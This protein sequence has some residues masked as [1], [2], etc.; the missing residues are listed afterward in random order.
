MSIDTSD[1]KQTFAAAVLALVIL[2]GA[3]SRILGRIL[4]WNGRAEVDPGVWCPMRGMLIVEEVDSLDRF[5]FSVATRVVSGNRTA[6]FIQCLLTL[7]S[8]VGGQELV[9]WHRRGIWGKDCKSSCSL[10]LQD[11]VQQLRE[12]SRKRCH[13]PAEARSLRDF[14]FPRALPVHNRASEPRHNKKCTRYSH[15]PTKT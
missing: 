2:A 15:N 14:S 1:V 11:H 6:V 13:W 12:L 7:L 8:N 10:S 5:S 4:S 9:P 3:L